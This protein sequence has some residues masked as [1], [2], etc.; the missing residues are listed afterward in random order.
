MAI[1]T[2]PRG[3]YRTRDNPAADADDV[4][5]KGV[6]KDRVFGPSAEAVRAVVRLQPL[7]PPSTMLTQRSEGSLATVQHHPLPRSLTAP[8]LGKQPLVIDAASNSL[9]PP[10]RAPRTILDD[11]ALLSRALCPFVCTSAQWSGLRPR[12]LRLLQKREFDTHDVVAARDSLSPLLVLL[13]GSVQ[14]GDEASLTAGQLVGG[15][16]WLFDA[17]TRSK[18]VATSPT[19]AYV[20]PR[21]ARTEVLALATPESL[22][23]HATRLISVLA[24][25]PTWAGVAPSDLW[26]HRHTA[27]TASLRAACEPASVH[28]LLH[29]EASWHGSYGTELEVGTL[30]VSS[31]P[32]T[33]VPSVGS[34]WVQLTRA[35]VA[36]L[37]GDDA[38]DAYFSRFEGEPKKMRSSGI[39]E[40]E[41]LHTLGAGAFASVSLAMHVPTSEICALKIIPKDGLPSLKLARQALTERD[42]LASVSSPFIARYVMSFQD[43]WNLY[44][45]S[46]FVPGGELYAR[47]HRRP[48]VTPHLDESAVLF[49]AA[50]L[51]LALD[52]FHSS[53]IVYRDLKLENVML[54]AN[55]YLK[56]VDCGFA[57]RVDDRQEA[58]TL[59]GTPEY[60]APELIA[61]RGYGRAVDYWALGALVYEMATGHSLFARDDDNQTLVM[62]RISAVATLGLPFTP[63]FAVACSPRLRTLVQG[64]LQVDPTR[65]LGSRGLREVQQHPAFV[66]MDWSALRSHTIGAPYVPPIE[67]PLDTQHFLHL[68]DE[69]DGPDGTESPPAELQ[70]AFATIFAQF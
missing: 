41:L 18:V 59:C 9:R 1:E 24:K 27:T 2:T 3:V 25:D 55:G 20:L 49:Y 44:L 64:L 40:Y 31:S 8:A 63:E 43:D 36:A 52:A 65:R 22:L 39:D 33:L 66:N 23:S 62:A 16:S 10:R 19:T 26:Q 32:R 4:P 42:V 5:S 6:G 61:G 46:E 30:L 68:D 48:A 13:S 54:G 11:L 69:Y 35:D 12:L 67:H 53:G 50:N 15:E 38:A 58:M 29:G 37:L 14:C 70:A 34:V 57:R 51:A 28:L 47:V 60:M 21:S 7:R 17:P 45:A 56:L